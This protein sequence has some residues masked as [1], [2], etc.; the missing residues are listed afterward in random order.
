MAQ[1]LPA[2]RTLLL[3]S[4]L[5]APALLKAQEVAA[6]KPP[7]VGDVIAASRAEDWRP[8]DPRYTLYAQLPGGRVVIELA[9]QFAPRHVANIEALV[10]EGYFN[11]LAVERVQD[12]F[13]AQLGDPDH[14]RSLGTAQ[15]A[16]PAEFTVAANDAHFTA[17]PDPDTYAAVVG[18]SDGF[19]AARD[20]K[21][22]REWLVNCYAMVGVGRDNDVDSGNGSE[23]YVVIGQAP[24]QLDRNATL[25]GRVV[26]GIEL[27]S[28]LPRG[29]GPLGFY[30]K[31]QQRVIIK[32]VRVAADV[33][34]PERAAL[35]V[36]RTDT[37]TFAELTEARRNRRDEWYKVPAGRIDICNIPLPVR[38]KPGL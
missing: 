18:F 5:L 12:N 25:V 29:T 7:T 17:L 9:P 34:A 4:L 10:R 26:E 6:K 33:P 21:T 35:E 36:M 22:G 23:L 31:P 27:L 20:L 2:A 30:D 37:A 32:S 19:P 15:H 8:L 14:S 28:A 3:A 24:R 11:G 1:P 13:V 38:V 16:L